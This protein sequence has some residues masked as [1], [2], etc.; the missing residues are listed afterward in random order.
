MT[1]ENRW[2]LHEKLAADCHRVADSSVGPI[3]LHRNAAVHWFLI[4]PRT[5]C[6]DLLDLPPDVLQ[7][8]LQVGRQLNRLLKEE[9]AYPRVN[10]GALGLLVPQLHLH[11]VG[12]RQDDD[13]WP[14][15][16][17]GNLAGDAVYAEG[18]LNRV[19]TL[20]SR[21]GFDTDSR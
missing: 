6:L 21:V 16:V 7:N 10:I 8:L 13:C 20:L 1:Q 14:A 5:T 3:L 11:V 18:E 19:S 9:F 2:E 12:R 15:P 17:W 4:V